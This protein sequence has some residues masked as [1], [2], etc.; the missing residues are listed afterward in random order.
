[1]LRFKGINNKPGQFEIVPA[2]NSPLVG[3]NITY[4]KKVVKNY[5]GSEDPNT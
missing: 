4:S 3:T 1:M 2:S 5:G